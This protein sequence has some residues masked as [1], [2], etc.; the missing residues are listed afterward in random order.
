MFDMLAPKTRW[1]VLLLVVLVC[2]G[3]SPGLAR[4]NLSPPF[5]IIPIDFCAITQAD[6]TVNYPFS[7]TNHFDLGSGFDYGAKQN[8]CPYF[9]VDFTVGSQ[10]PVFD[11]QMLPWDSLAYTQAQ[12]TT[13]KWTVRYYRSTAGAPFTL[14][15]TATYTG[16]WNNPA[17][18]CVAPGNTV[19]HSPN[20][21]F[22]N[23]NLEGAAQGTTDT[24]RM[25]ERA[26]YTKPSGVLTTLP[27]L[28]EVFDSPDYPPPVPTC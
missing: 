8:G 22:G 10:P 16:T 20:L 7:Q 12:C 1:L 9:V 6:A 15:A 13:L 19:Y 26:T 5:P 27:V 11:A 25:I 21:I 4:A 17:G 24:I 28:A 3:G 23:C 18:W 14:I 2:A